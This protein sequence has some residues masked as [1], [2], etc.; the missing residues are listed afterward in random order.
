MTL[1][2]KLEVEIMHLP[3]T[4]D[5]INEIGIELEKIA[6]EFAIGFAEWFFDKNWNKNSLSSSEFKKQLK[7]YKL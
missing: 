4:D 1:K 6:D 3:L 7:I 2:D 5:V